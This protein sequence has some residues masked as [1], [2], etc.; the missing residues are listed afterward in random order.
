MIQFKTTSECDFISNFPERENI[1][2]DSV[3]ANMTKATLINTA[4][5][6]WNMND[7]EHQ[8]KAISDSAL[9]ILRMVVQTGIGSMDDYSPV[10]IKLN[11]I[12]K[13]YLYVNRSDHFYKSI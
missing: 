1:E 3:R 13:A 6:D 10:L 8:A 11:E 9:R 4:L 2:D 5:V 12:T 7:L